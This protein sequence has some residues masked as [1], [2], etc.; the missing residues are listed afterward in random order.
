MQRYVATLIFLA[1][2]FLTPMAQA[3]AQKQ[4]P[5]APAVSAKASAKP[6]GEDDLRPP[7]EEEGPIGTPSDIKLLGIAVATLASSLAFWA[8]YR[9]FRKKIEEKKKTSPPVPPE[10]AAYDALKKIRELMDTDGKAFYFRLCL[11]FREYTGRR[12]NVNATEM[13]TE[14]LL[15]VLRSLPLERNLASDASR[16]LAYSDP[17]KYAGA[18]PERTKMERHFK[19]VR[20][21]VKKTTDAISPEKDGAGQA[22]QSE[23]ATSDA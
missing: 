10:K 11:A 9:H 2:L 14:E 13:T 3:F 20:L 12:F 17:V 18:V 16:F 7:K 19:F 22:S 8:T 1:V 21:F 5:V 15:P 23:T 4:N 6:S